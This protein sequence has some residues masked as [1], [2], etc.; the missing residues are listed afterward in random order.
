M[1]TLTGVLVVVALPVGALI[2]LLKIVDALQRRRDARIARQ[3]EVTDAIHREFGAIVAPMVRRTRGGGW[4]V[5]LRM[6]PRHPSAARVVELAALTL[7]P[8]A[9]VEV[10]VTATPASPRRRAAQN[11]ERIASAMSA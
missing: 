6:D 8:T 4:R 10:A 5:T 1:L 11:S 3:I 7:G 2:A 9:T